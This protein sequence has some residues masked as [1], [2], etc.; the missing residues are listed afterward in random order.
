MTV[1]LPL[2]R[3]SA[4]VSG[5]GV[6]PILRVCG[7]AGSANRESCSTSQRLSPPIAKK[8][9]SMRFPIR[10][11][12]RPIECTESQAGGSFQ[13]E[14]FA[15]VLIPCRYIFLAFLCPSAAGGNPLPRIVHKVL[16][17][18]KSPEVRQ[19]KDAND[20]GFQAFCYL[21]DRIA[22]RWL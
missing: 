16:N 9:K 12:F 11:Y 13:R 20:L 14:T 2:S 3:Y 1:R 8:R 15:R 18:A 5:R 19:A 21:I 6:P 4:F 10:L 7:F 22:M 17:F